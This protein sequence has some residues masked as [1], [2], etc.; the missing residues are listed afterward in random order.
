MQCMQ[1]RAL[2]QKAAH[3]APHCNGKPARRAP[4][5]DAIDAAAAAVAADFVPHLAR[6][7]ERAR[8]AV[9]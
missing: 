9:P 1:T 6:R 4:A 8:D 3:G 5:G 7:Y 2:A